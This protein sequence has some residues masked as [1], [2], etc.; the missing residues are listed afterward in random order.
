MSEHN[1]SDFCIL[2]FDELTNR[3]VRVEKF[4][5]QRTEK[6]NTI[7]KAILEIQLSNKLI[8]QTLSKLEE[9]FEN[10]TKDNSDKMFK[11]LQKSLYILFGI[12]LAL[13]GYKFNILD[14]LR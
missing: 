7:E 6:E 13:L 11:V 5:E 9:R 2:K 10:F 12:I 3:L 14:L 4:N 1:Q 8:A